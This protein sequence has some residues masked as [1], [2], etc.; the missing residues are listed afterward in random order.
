MT[1]TKTEPMSEERLR[2]IESWPKMDGVST[3]EDCVSEIRRLQADQKRLCDALRPVVDAIK[4]QDER[5]GL[6]DAPALYGIAWQLAQRLRAV[7]R[8]IEGG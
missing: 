1:E 3:L 7:L 2:A 5:P 8:E 6:T 4:E